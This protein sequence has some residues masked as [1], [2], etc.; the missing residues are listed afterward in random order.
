MQHTNVKDS[1]VC[2]LGQRV[3]IADSAYQLV[4]EWALQDGFY[5][6]DSIIA[7]LHCPRLIPRQDLTRCTGLCVLQRQMTT[8]IAIGF[9]VF[10]IGIR[11]GLE[12]C[13]CTIN[14]HTQ[15]RNKSKT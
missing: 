3:S 5:S 2:F 15:Y 8:Q 13:E 12:Q 9:C 1:Y 4:F 14:L 6:A 7:Y 10:A 11:F